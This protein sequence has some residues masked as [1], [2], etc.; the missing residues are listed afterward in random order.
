MRNK[1]IKIFSLLFVLVFTLVLVGCGNSSEEQLL[2]SYY[3]KLTVSEL[4][5]NDFDLPYSIDYKDD[6]SISWVSSKSNLKIEQKK[7]TP[8]YKVTVTREKEDVSVELTATIKLNSGLSKDKLFNL[9]IKAKQEEV[10]PNPNP[11]PDPSGSIKDQFDC[12]SIADIIKIANECGETESTEKYYVYGTIKTISNP[13]YGEMIITDGVNEISVYGTTDEDGNLYSTLSDKPVKGD[14]IVVYGSVK[15]FKDSPEMSRSI[16]KA[17]K[18]ITPE[19]DEK[20]YQAMSVAEARKASADTKMK[21]S[22]VV[23]FITNANGFKPNGFYLVDNTGSIYIYGGDTAQQVT[24]GNTVTV[25]GEKTY[26]I[27]PD[28]SSSA[29]KYGYEGSCQVQNVT[30]ISNDKGNTEFDKTWIKESNVKDILETK[31]ENNVNIT[32]D[33]FKVN[34]LIK[35]VPGS[36]FVNYYINDLDGKTSSYVYT[37]CNGDD[38]AWLDEFDNKICTV[39]LSPINCKATSAGLIYRFIPVKVEYNNFK[40]DLADACSHA[41]KYYAIDQFKKLY[42]NNPTLE[43]ITSVS[44]ELLGFE[45]VQLTYKSSNENVVYFENNIMNT[46]DNGEAI[47]TI[48][49]KLGEYTYTAE[50]VIKVENAEAVDFISVKE[51][52]ETPDETVV[53]VKGIVVASLVNQ[54]GFYLGD[55][56][57]VIAVTTSADILSEMELGKEVIIEGTRIHRKKDP[58]GAEA[59]Q[60]VISDAKLLV[61]FYGNHQY[62]KQSFISGKTID[63]IYN[64]DYTQD[65]TT[66]VYIVTGK[67]II[68]DFGYYS[69]ITIKDENGVNE[70]RLYSSSAKQYNWLKEFEGK[71]VTLEVAPTNWNSK[72]YYTGCFISAT[73]GEKTLINNLNFA[74]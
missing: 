21:L 47:I 55:E 71:V 68:Q 6:H 58:A 10:N 16:I 35:K 62:S 41:I 56:T 11:N 40:F 2:Q 24:I 32:G 8:G 52:V 22:G 7:V 27:N 44:S 74:N 59:G 20:E 13:T 54:T 70:L 42:Q 31:F 53:T 25:I 29:K 15:M 38:F 33:I 1:L 61:N 37:A 14:E 69:N 65:Y 39:Y 45:N 50:V 73:D 48:T 72:N 30:L 5:E 17:F 46:K 9:T 12:T 43:V 19:Y 4:V 28:E 36:G 26:Y 66:N 23:A 34:A 51:A 67:I 3:D 57:G 63:D 64:L 18:H 60:S 49:A